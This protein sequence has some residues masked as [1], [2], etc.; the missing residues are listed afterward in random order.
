MK[1]D[2]YTKS[3]LTVIAFCL[4][5]LVLRG[6][7]LLPRA[8]AGGVAA[9]PAQTLQTSRPLLVN[10]DG[11]INVRVTGLEGPL[12]V[13][14]AAVGGSLVYGKVPVEYNK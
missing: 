5:V 10:N 4:V 9:A 6:V 13:N 2:A 3:V 8:T 7:D 11:S 14:V 1:T 12:N